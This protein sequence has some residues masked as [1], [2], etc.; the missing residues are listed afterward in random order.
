MSRAELM[1]CAEARERIGY[2]QDTGEFRL[3]KHL[4]CPSA[5]GRRTRALDASGYVQ[6]NLKPYGPIKGHRLAWLIHYG[7]WPKG[8]IDHI[9]G[10]RDD[11]R[12]CNL[13][14]VTNKINCQNKRK[15]L[16][17]NKVGMLGVTKQ[18]RRY[19][20]NV[21]LNRKQ[22][23]LGSFDSPEAA[24]AAYLDGKR[25]LHDGCTM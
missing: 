12:I 7:E 20:A 19:V 18:G 6:I 9:N 13:R 11:N 25:K 5:V 24:H 8:H 1:S 17:S 15:P 23:Y 10:I 14:V 21:M 2:D 3:L 4:R 16:P 22:H